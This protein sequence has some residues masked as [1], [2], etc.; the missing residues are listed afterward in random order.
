MAANAARD[1][2]PSTVA[3][4]PRPPLE[5]VRQVEP[6]SPTPASDRRLEATMANESRVWRAAAIGGGAGFALVAS[7]VTLAGTASGIAAGSALG[8]GIFV[9]IFSGGG[10]GFMAGAVAALARQAD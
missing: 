1:A 4:P 8:I 7:V 3:A 9:G 10:F 6:A 5:V 2:T